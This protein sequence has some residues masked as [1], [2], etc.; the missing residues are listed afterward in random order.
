[1]LLP[2][3][4]A[5]LAMSLPAHLCFCISLS[6]SRTMSALPRLTAREMAVCTAG[7]AGEVGEAGEAG[8]AAR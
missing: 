8:E 4:L 5:R 2:T 3:D 6:S 7:E 1:M